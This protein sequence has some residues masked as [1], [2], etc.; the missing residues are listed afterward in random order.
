[1]AMDKSDKLE[2]WNTIIDEKSKTYYDNTYLPW[3]TKEQ[4]EL[5]KQVLWSTTSGKKIVIQQNITATW[6]VPISTGFEITWVTAYAFN[7]WNSWWKSTT[8][9]NKSTW[10]SIWVSEWY[11]F[12][13]S[14][15]I[16]N[17]SDINSNNS[18]LRIPEYNTS[19]NIRARIENI[20]SSW[21][22]LNIYEVW[23]S[24]YVTI[25]LDCF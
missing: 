1:M 21:F 11:S 14:Y 9:Y 20:T 13:W 22:D 3:E 5:W 18:A 12:N 16:S 19:K 10:Y 25:I 24:W 4:L 6:I 8:V 15:V 7:N 2:V 17:I 23:Y